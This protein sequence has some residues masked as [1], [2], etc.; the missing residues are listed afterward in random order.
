MPLSPSTS[1][2]SR[3]PWIAGA[4][5]ALLLVLVVVVVALPA[6]LVTRVLPPGVTASD[7]SGG[8]WHGAAGRLSVNGRDSGAIEWQLHPGDLPRLQLGFDATWARGTFALSGSGTLSRHGLSLSAVHGGG[9]I[10]DIA[11]LTGMN[12]WHGTAAIALDRLAADF[13]QLRA[14]SGDIRVSG[15]HNATI[16]ADDD[17]GGYTL[18]FDPGA[19]GP[20]GAIVGQLRDDGGPLE[21]G[22]T[23]QL[24][25]GSRLGT[26]HGTVRERSQGSGALR[27][28]IEQLAQMSPRDAQGRVPLDVEFAY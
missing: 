22:A 11:P 14:L 23:V 6:S 15:L 20:D 4:L 27:R 26:L 8:L 12:G 3:G 7:L 18:H 24:D 9:A 5:F 28:S 19:T 17:L 25:P 16:G 10:E 21:V 13:T 2:S 1:R